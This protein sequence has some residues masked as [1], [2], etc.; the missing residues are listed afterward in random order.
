MAT[1]FLLRDSCFA[2]NP[3]S[4]LLKER[5]QWIYSYC[6]ELNVTFLAYFNNVSW[7]HAASGN[8]ICHVCCSDF[9]NCCLEILSKV[10]RSSTGLQFSSVQFSRSV[11]SYS[12]WSHELQHA[13][14]PYPSP[15]SGVHPKSCPS[16]SV[17]PFSSCPQC[18]PA[19]ES[20]PMSQTAVLLFC[21]SFPWGWSWSL[22]PVQCH[23]PPSI[24][25]VHSKIHLPS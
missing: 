4:F 2:W 3:T 12:L 7:K 11:I 14:P 16:S 17:V 23:K 8:V 18:L 9:E 5:E 1:P 24:C 25:L 13:R 22:S 15:I 20:F 21:I 10:I 6:V 19:S